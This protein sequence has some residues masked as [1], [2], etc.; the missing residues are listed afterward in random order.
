M[1]AGFIENLPA[2]VCLLYSVIAVDDD[3]IL[4]T[5]IEVVAVR[6][7]VIPPRYG[8]IFDTEARQDAVLHAEVVDIQMAVVEEDPVRGV[9]K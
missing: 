1:D 5:E 9:I 8:E 2:P 6:K 7:P 4:V 3:N